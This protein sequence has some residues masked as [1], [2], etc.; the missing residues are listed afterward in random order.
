MPP[1]SPFAVDYRF[2]RADGRTRWVRDRAE[3]VTDELGRP[4]W[5]GFIIDIT[6]QKE[7]EDRFRTLV[8]AL[9]AAT[10]TYDETAHGSAVPPLLHQSAVRRDHRIRADEF[11]ADDTALWARLL[12]PRDAARVR[13]ADLGLRGPSAECEE[14]RIRT[15]RRSQVRWIYDEQHLFRER[16]R[17]SRAAGSACC[18]TS[19]TAS[20]P[21]RTPRSFELCRTPPTPTVAELLAR[22]VEAQE[23]SAGGSPPTSTTTPS[24]R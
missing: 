24:R 9:P 22:I 4:M 6:E 1:E 3:L 10:Y 18:S 23:G 14:Y 11:L 16:R 20:R 17:A 15:K 21:R 13:E 12:H 2:I 8:E 7:A 19:P 5:Q